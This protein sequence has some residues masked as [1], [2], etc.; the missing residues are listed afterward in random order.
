MVRTERSS[1][2]F[3]TVLRQQVPAEVAASVVRAEEAV[4]AVTELKE[5][6][7]EVAVVV[8]VA[9][10]AIKAVVV[11]VMAREVAAVV[12]DLELP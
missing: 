4:A 6:E 7:T 1:K 12:A 5:V 10:V 11:V 8:A 2:R 3:Q 9:A